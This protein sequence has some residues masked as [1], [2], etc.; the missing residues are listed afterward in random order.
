VVR[1]AAREVV[2]ADPGQDVTRLKLYYGNPR[3]E[4][5]RYDFARNLPTTLEPAPARLT[6]A[7]RRENPDYR[8]APLP[9]T[10]RWPWAIYVILGAVSLALGLIIISLARTA[11][12]VHDAGRAAAPL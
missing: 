10:E 5:P 4:S 2:F 8:P 9:F 7:E 6:L 11:I 3:A 12:R 1:A